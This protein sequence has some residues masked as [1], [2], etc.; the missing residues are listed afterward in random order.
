[1]ELTGIEARLF[2]VFKRATTAKL[3]L[4]AVQ[5]SFSLA[6]PELNN[7]TERRARLADALGNLAAH[8]LIALPVNHRKDWQT[9]AAPPLPNWIRLIREKLPPPAKQFDHSQFPWVEEM[10]FVAAL[11]TLPAPVEARQLHEFFKN[12]GSRLPIVPTK[13]RS[14]QIFGEE[15]RLEEL[16]P[17]KLF[18]NSGRLSLE[19]LRCRPVS[20]SLIYQLA[21][22]T[23]KESPIILENEA[24]FHSF[25][26]L[27][28]VTSSFSAVVLGN[29][30]AV[31]KGTEFLANLARS[32]NQNQFLYFG[33]LDASGLRIAAELSKQLAVHNLALVPAEQFY[34]ELLATPERVQKHV[35]MVAQ[36]HLNWLPDD[37]SVLVKT[38]LARS[39]RIAQEALGWER[40]SSLFSIDPNTDFFSG[41]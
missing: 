6:C 19:M 16:L 21:S 26:R 8:R 7:Q 25:V 38:R 17:G 2:T 12:G 35:E 15:K 3:P 1:M 41:F 22:T 34:R 29:G 32:L 4:D 39:G 9:F 37:L 5:E 23:N 28:A 20:Y 14:W 24:T 18:F 13:E 31:L 40:L 33:D 10:R 36:S 27:T 30:Q 11:P